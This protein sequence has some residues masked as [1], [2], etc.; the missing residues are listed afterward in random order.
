MLFWNTDEIGVAKLA[1]LGHLS[2]C[3]IAAYGILTTG[4]TGKCSLNLN[5]DRHH[6]TYALA[7]SEREEH[8]LCVFKMSGSLFSSY[9]NK[10]QRNLL[11]SCDAPYTLGMQLL[12]ESSGTFV[13]RK[14]HGCSLE[15]H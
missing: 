2:F 1:G 12:Q 9:G 14:L 11:I 7:V 10:T 15:I 6:L 5:K 8:N 4:P 3:L 13:I